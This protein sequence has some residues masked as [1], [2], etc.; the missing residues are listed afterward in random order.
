[1][2]PWIIALIVI[3]A[4]IVLLFLLA[5]LSYRFAF[6]RRY[7]KGKL[8]KY[9]TAEDFGLDAEK[10]SI[11]RKK[12]SLCGILYRK[13]DVLQKDSVVVFVH[14]MGA[15]HI[16]YT[17]EMNY[18]CNLGYPVIALDSKGCNLSGGKNIKGMYCTI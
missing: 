6:G 7:D 16:A 12:F 4:V 2:Q 3:S 17:T 9:F 1:M 15:G 18:F 5:A 14:G 8:L 13:A 11:P 10:I